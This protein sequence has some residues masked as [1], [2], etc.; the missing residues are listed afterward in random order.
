MHPLSPITSTRPNLCCTLAVLTWLVAA[1][2]AG[3]QSTWYVD[4]TGIPP[5]SG[6]DADP[7]TDIAYAI[8]RPTMVNGDRIL[9][10]PGDYTGDFS[11]TSKTLTVESTDGPAHTRIHGFVSLGSDSPGSLSKLAGFRVDHV[12]LFGATLERC[13]LL[14]THTPGA[15]AVFIAD[16]ARI[17]SCTIAGFDTVM[18]EFTFSTFPATIRNSI[19]WDFGVL[20]SSSTGNDHVLQYNAGQLDGPFPPNWIVDGNVVG[21]PGC[22][23][24]AAGDVHLVPGSICIDAGDPA[25]P[26]DPDGSR[27]D[28]GALPFDAGYGPTPTAYCV[29]K[30]NGQ[31]CVP[32]MSASGFCS[33]TSGQPFWVTATD[34][35]SNQF[36][37]LFYGFEQAAIPFLGGTRCIAQP[38][39]RTSLFNSGGTSAPC[40]GVLSYD[41]NAPI[42]SGV[43]PSLV[44]GTLVYAQYW[45]RD[46]ADP[47]GFGIGLSNALCF[48]IAP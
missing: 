41:F 20:M 4:V 48:G 35:S 16:L 1:G 28:I 45:Y 26:L 14:D 31:G 27:V 47:A 38:L 36:G 11:Y 2:N 23:N 5:G 3:A 30:L 29:G 9:V 21:D 32:Q 17:E 7:Y 8:A 13:V 10:R 24:L 6:T 43:D 37:R 46:P 15:H 40:S 33:A 39:T 25:S 42:Q 19:L 18:Q 12:D 34:V 22:W 44:P